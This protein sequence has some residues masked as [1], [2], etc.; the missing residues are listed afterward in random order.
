[1]RISLAFSYS[2]TIGFLVTF[3]DFLMP[4]ASRC[5]ILSRV[6]SLQAA[7]PT[8]YTT[9]AS[10]PAARSKKEDRGHFPFNLAETLKE[11]VEPFEELQDGR[12]C[13]CA[14]WLW[15]AAAD[16][17]ATPPGRY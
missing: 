6:G 13:A 3:E 1:M 4:A 5:C 17:G 7:N 8:Q 11:A 12:E 14:C 15:R 10:R 2:S 16:R 9:I